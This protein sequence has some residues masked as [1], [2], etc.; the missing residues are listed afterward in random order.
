MA[1]TSPYTEKVTGSIP[2]GPISRWQ[3][4]SLFDIESNSVRRTK[5]WIFGAKKALRSFY[6]PVGPI[7][8]GSQLI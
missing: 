2:V 7:A 6:G 1:I 8:G 4:D 5:I 3:L